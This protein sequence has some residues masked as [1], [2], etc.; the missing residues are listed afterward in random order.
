M[1][2]ERMGELCKNDG[3][4]GD[5]IWGLTYVG[6]R[7]HVLYSGVKVRFSGGRALQAHCKVRNGLLH[8]SPL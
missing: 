3:K 6:P 8:T 5:A 4:D 2:A 1:C 7:N